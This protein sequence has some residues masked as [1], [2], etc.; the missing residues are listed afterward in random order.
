MRLRDWTICFVCIIAAGILFFAASVR[1]DTIHN[2][3]RDM[4]LVSNEP[5]ENAPP[6]LAFATVAMGAFRGLVVDM[7]WMRAEKLKEDGQFFDARQLAEWI[8]ILQPRFASVWDFHAWN[9]A[10]NISVAMPADQWEERWHWV[11][12]GYELLRDKGIETN[13]HS[14]ILYRSLAWIFQHK[15]GGVNDDCHKHYKRELALS[16]RP[17]LG[18]NTN[19]YFELLAKA[20]KNFSDIA[21]RKDIGQLIADLKSAETAF[22]DDDR[23]ADNYLALRQ[24]PKKFPREAFDIIDKFRNTKTLEDFD[25]F[26]KAYALRHR[27]KL[28]PEFMLSLNNQYGPIEPGDPNNRLPLNWEHPD[29]HAIYWGKLGLET[30]G[31]KGVYS[32]DE[33]NTDRIVFHSLQSLYRTGKL[34]IYPVPERLPSVFVRPDLRMFDSCSKAWTDVIDKYEAMERSNPK[35]VRGGYKNFLINSIALFYQAGQTKKAAKI[36]EE[37]RERYPLDEFNV[38]LL[39]F[40][41]QRML[42]E[43][44]DITLKDA[45]E[46]ILMSLVEAYFR[47]AIHEDAEALARENWSKQLYDF[48]QREQIWEASREIFR[49]DMPSFEMMK[50]LAFREFVFSTSYPEYMR[51]RLLGRMEIERPDVLEELKKQFE[52][53]NEQIQNQ[54]PNP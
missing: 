30:A 17:L 18:D 44:R 2:A 14:I 37:L 33:K 4:G 31:Q 10:Y 20:P 6:S 5:L 22:K 29:V 39:T 53:L 50:Y 19:E 12:N 24:F 35:A 16:I 45:T 38:P 52:I 9:M 36:F 3:R 43:A 8:T 26:A 42:E 54:K 28:D 51:Q 13:P 48:Y 15:I 40:V 32:V 7:L 27:L 47:Y 49:V 25:I 21:G 1:L 11:K 46:S 41:Q 23:F 34:I